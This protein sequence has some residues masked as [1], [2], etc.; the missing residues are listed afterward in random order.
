[1]LPK[2]SELMSGSLMVLTENESSQRQESL[3]PAPAL[4]LVQREGE[5]KPRAGVGIVAVLSGYTWSISHL[6]E[7]LDRW[8]SKLPT[9]GG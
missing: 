7:P 8:Q 5:S 6:R 9:A 4:M 1:M 3:L 2:P